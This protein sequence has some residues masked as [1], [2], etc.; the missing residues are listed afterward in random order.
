MTG[1]VGK[2]A[3]G[4][5]QNH[6]EVLSSTASSSSSH[7]QT[8]RKHNNCNS[9]ISSSSN[10]SSDN[11]PPQHHQGRRRD[12]GNVNTSQQHSHNI[13]NSSRQK[14]QGRGG[15]SNG[16]NAAAF[17]K[18]KVQSALKK[19]AKEKVTI[20][21][22]IAQNNHMFF[23]AGFCILA[24]IVA[25][26]LKVKDISPGALRKE[27]SS[28][29]SQNS[30]LKNEVNLLH[31]ENAVLY[32]RILTL[33]NHLM[34][35]SSQYTRWHTALNEDIIRPG[36]EHIR[37]Y[38]AVVP[39]GVTPGSGFEVVVDG[40]IYLVA[41]PK[42]C[43]QGDTVAFDLLAQVLSQVVDGG[44]V[45]MPNPPPPSRYSSVQSPSERG[46]IIKNSLL[47][48]SWEVVSQSTN[49]TRLTQRLAS[50][51]IH[52]IRMRDEGLPKIVDIHDIEAKEELGRKSLENISSSSSVTLSAST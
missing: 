8:S 19:R 16:K 13:I 15:K 4:Q 27:I 37:P 32:N 31:Q 39:E 34:E 22:L 48:K 28:Y 6:A 52:W 41:C 25:A 10:G 40:Q 51:R 33:H 44:L 35:A 45:N 30:V 26:L 21:S 1:S 47:K 42:G 12:G 2:K 9:S 36:D 17:I 18:A 20:S 50:P 11:N 43:K 24:I 5:Q 14:R 38:T 7:R 29:K 46:K 49:V 23:G 3:A